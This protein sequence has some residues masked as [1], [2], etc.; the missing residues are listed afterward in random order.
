QIG[1]AGAGGW[2][3]ILQ[4]VSLLQD[5]GSDNAGRRQR[6]AMSAAEDA[7]MPVEALVE[8]VLNESN[9]NV[10][11]AIRWAL[12]Q[13]G[14]PQDDSPEDALALLAAALRAPSAEVRK[15]A[16]ESIA[17]FPGPEATAQ[18]Q[19]ALTST[20]ERIRRY[21]AVAL[22]SR[23]AAGAVPT[24]VGMIVANRNDADAADALSAL[25]GHPPLADQIAGVLISRI[26]DL[27]AGSR[28]D[29]PGMTP[30]IRRRSGDRS[31]D[32]REKT[33]DEA[34]TQPMQILDSAPGHPERIVDEVPA[35]GQAA[36]RQRLTQALADIPGAAATRYLTELT[37]DDDRAVALTAAYVLTLR[38]AT[39]ESRP[40]QK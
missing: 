16:V 27:K 39:S 5:L 25:A 20:D 24:L 13:T 2:E 14:T 1:V 12:V 32:P 19:D 33:S 29:S 36:A 34:P 26:T 22:G 6:A 7:S 40:G 18:L 21:A 3:D 31:P 4:I 8:A 9:P 17:E 11:G 28:A 30:A 23:G 37:G 10:A 35:G 15:R 38:P